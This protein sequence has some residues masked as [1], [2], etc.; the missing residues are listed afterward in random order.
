[1]S[2]GQG[3]GT[4]LGTGGLGLLVGHSSITTTGV[5]GAASLGLAVAGRGDL[6]GLLLAMPLVLGPLPPLALL[7]LGLRGLLG[8]LG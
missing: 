1:M 4:V 3:L 2:M 8:A 6:L 7:L 5:A